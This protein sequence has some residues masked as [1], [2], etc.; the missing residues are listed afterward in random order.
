[1]TEDLKQQIIEEFIQYCKSVLKI[2]ALPPIQFTNDRAW[3]TERHSF[4]EYDPTKNTLFVYIGNRNLADILRTLGHELVHHKQ[5]ELGVLKNGSG[6]TGSEIENEANSI[7]GVLMRNYGKTNELIYEIKTPS[8]KEIYEEEKVSRLKIY[9][10]MDGVLCDFD[11]RFEDF[12]NVS[13]SEYRKKYTPD[14]SNEYLTKAVDEAGVQFWSK[15]PWMPGGKELWAKISPYNP[16]I[17]TSPGNFKFAI[18][19]KKIWIKENLSPQPKSVFFAKAGNK[20]LV[21]S[22]KPESEIKNSILIDDYFPNLAPWKQLGGIG[23]MHK[24]FEGTN[25]ILN[26]F[27]L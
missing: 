7:A 8:L 22:D 18:E 21:I 4:G 3:A 17:L 23:I 27:N 19:G 25:S 26:K 13:P 12:Y 1:M 6:Q 9:C 5:N 24:S 10:D 15:M 14:K 16:A 2:D 11:K 20:H